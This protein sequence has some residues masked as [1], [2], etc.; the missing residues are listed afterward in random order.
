MKINK[1]QISLQNM[2]KEDK[3]VEIEVRKNFT[4]FV[5]DDS[6]TE[7]IKCTADDYKEKISEIMNKNGY[8]E[9]ELNEFAQN[10]GF[11]FREN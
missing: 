3:T 7:I 4:R 10:K 2:N 5:A 6:N 9:E 1:F 11:F 8:G